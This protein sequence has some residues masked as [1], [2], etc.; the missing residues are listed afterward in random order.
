MFKIG[1]ITKTILVFIAVAYFWQDT[2]QRGFRDGKLEPISK[3]STQ[4]K[5]CIEE[6]QI[7]ALKRLENYKVVCNSIMQK[8][9]H[10]EESEKE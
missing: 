1:K 10:P 4:Y 5:S 8:Y 6:G 7:I 9:L 3:K 2:Y